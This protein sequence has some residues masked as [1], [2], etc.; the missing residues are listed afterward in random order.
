[1]KVLLF[2]TALFLVFMQPLAFADIKNFLNPNTPKQSYQ[3]TQ[4]S[5][6][7]P[8]A[9]VM[10][11]KEPM[12]PEPKEPSISPIAET[13]SKAILS[14]LNQL[15]QTML[16]NQQQINTHFE[17]LSSQQSEITRRLEKL[18]QAL[19]MMNQQLSKDTPQ[20]A[21]PEPTDSGDKLSVS[22]SVAFLV[23]I[24]LALFVGF[25]FIRQQKVKQPNE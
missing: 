16:L 17:S 15:G 5:N 11:E 18:T 6:S 1:M 4:D 23:L 12:S 19:V 7:E 22:D 24:G 3:S 25:V 9:P 8:Q 2:L 21:S 14:G 10:P 13:D 20:Q